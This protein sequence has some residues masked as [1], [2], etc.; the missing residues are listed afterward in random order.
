MKGYVYP[1]ILCAVFLFGA[2][3]VS[4]AFAEMK[5]VD[6]A[7]MAKTKASVT[8][9]SVKD[10]QDNSVLDSKTLDK[11]LPVY[12][13]LERNISEAFGLELPGPPGTWTNTFGD[14]GVDNPYLWRGTITGFT[15][16]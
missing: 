14:V 2:V 15:V 12:T 10:W 4:P 8:G 1:S 3:F 16:R 9:A 13:P 5:K 11:T 7:E 6:D